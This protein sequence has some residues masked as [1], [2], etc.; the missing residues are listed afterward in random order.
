[1]PA[2]LRFTSAPPTSCRLLNLC[3]TQ[4]IP[5]KPIDD[6]SNSCK[7][8][9]TFPFVFCL[10][11][12]L[13]PNLPIILP[14]RDLM[15]PCYYVD[16]LDFLFLSYYLINNTFHKTHEAYPNDKLLKKSRLCKLTCSTTM[17][18]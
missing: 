6:H 9:R 13:W 10:F 14:Q 17:L 11:H 5:T 18:L 16:F 2:G 1:M 12:V 3:S 4:N 7:D 15:Q 8:H